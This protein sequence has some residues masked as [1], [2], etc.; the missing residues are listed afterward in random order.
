MKKLCISIKIAKSCFYHLDEMTTYQLVG[1]IDRTTVG[2]GRA[3]EEI[4]QEKGRYDL[5]GKTAAKDIPNCRLMVI[6]EVGHIPHL[7]VP[8]KFRQI[9]LE[10]L[11]Q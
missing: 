6:P 8:E 10:F 2:R 9:L 5:L 3:P 1:L 11:S 7:E 4:L